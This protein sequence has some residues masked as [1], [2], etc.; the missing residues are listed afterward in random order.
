[1]EALDKSAEV[2]GVQERPDLTDRLERARDRLQTRSATVA[3]VGEFKR[4]KSTLVNALIQ[5]A[6]CPVDADIVTAVPTLVRYGEQ[7]RV[8]AHEQGSDGSETVA[9]TVQPAEL[10]ALVSEP[11][12]AHSTAVRSVEI[13][14]PHRI[15]RAGLR[16]LDTPGVGGLESVHGQIS[17]ASLVGVDG[18]LFVTDAS[19]ELTAPELDFLRSA[20]ER[21]PTV[22]LVVTKTDLHHTWPRIVEL[23]RE[24]LRQA[25]IDVPVIPVSSFLRL[26]AAKQPDLN[27]ESGFGPLVEF[28]ARDVVQGATTRTAGR[29]AHEVD[30]VATQLARQSD[31]ER[32]VLA[33][34]ERGKAVLEGLESE[35][36][37]SHALSTKEAT[38]QQTLADGI[39]DLVADIEFDL[40][41]RL[42]GVLRGVK[43]II[44]G[45]DPRTTWTE[46]EGWLRRSAAAAGVANR[47]LLLRR[48][49]E[50]AASVATQ[51]NLDAGE[52]VEVRL[53][54]V[55]RALEERHL[56]AVSSFTM[57]GG[58][59]A[60]L[61]VTARTAGLV[62]MVAISLA[63]TGL[64]PIAVLTG[65][66]VAA[67][68]G[69]SGKLFRDEGKRQRAYR[70]SQAI[71]AAGKFVDEV[72]F[73]MNKETRDALRL[74]QR[75]LRDEFQG[76]ARS[77]QVS[78]TGALAAAQRAATLPSEARTR[79]ASELERQTEQL[80]SI[81][82]RLAEVSRAAPVLSGAGA[83]RDA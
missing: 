80:S 52:A 67:G 69:V 33:V 76:R 68:A 64:L 5:R 59:L 2:A 70:Q 28:L 49:Q 47:D 56:P 35:H 31:A 44:E 58:R 4:G 14:V 38:W 26:R 83:G 15:L 60:S 51:F 20:L 54:P 7:I 23:D 19:Q 21:C 43:E 48:A 16:L 82:D 78:S 65:A 50:L 30:F 73:E 41:A 29:L 53:D 27:A 10:R 24:H 46:T 11:S 3:V 13:E 77:L 66:A 71:A 6:V 40:Q 34:P 42:R 12:D 8:T 62:P 25:G 79:R 39:Q 63:S 1:M 45:T 17:L 9:R 18:V 81:Q 37:R 72:A 55:V 74:T 22:A 36:K 32:A 57:P 61:M 75:Q